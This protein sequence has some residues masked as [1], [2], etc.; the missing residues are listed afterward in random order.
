MAV[1]LSAL[2]ALTA[3]NDTVVQTANGSGGRTLR[4]FVVRDDWELQW[5]ARGGL[6]QAFLHV[7]TS[8]KVLG[9]IANQPKD[10]A[11]ASY[12]RNGGRYYLEINAIGDWTVRIV[13]IE[14][15]K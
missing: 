13:Q 12:Q 10:G 4:P 2:S 5:D 6:F 7:G 8:G 1:L 15:A 14:Q 9:I 11:G 3:A